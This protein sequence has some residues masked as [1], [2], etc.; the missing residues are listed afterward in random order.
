MPPFRRMDAMRLALITSSFALALAS[1]CDCDGASDNPDAAGGG[2]DGAV[3]RDGSSGADSG[4]GGRDASAT[5]RD[6]S[7]SAEVCDGVDND[8]NGIVDDVDVGGDGICDCL[9]IATLGI[10]G[11]WGNGDVFAAW[12]DARSDIGATALTDQV[13]T[14][15]L[16]EPYQ[17]IVA[18]DIRGREYSASEVDALRQWIEA[19]GGFMTLIG[20]GDPSE[21]TNVNALLMPS[22][23]QYD[24]TPILAGSPTVPITTWHPHPVSMSVTQ[25]GVDNGYEVI[26]AG[27]VIAEEGGFDVLRAV[28]L[29]Q[30]KVL[31][32]GDEW[33][34]YDSE[35]TGH[36]E[37]QLERFWLNAIKWLTPQDECQVPILI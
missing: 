24:A 28:E 8:G 30:G 10:A 9:I 11:E 29:G 25:V 31:V 20:Y 1:G 23:I 5:G 2:G 6:G 16:L 3:V 22:G 26:G 21:R 4:G 19:G 35:W 18:E 14:P 36:P 33:I 15:E 27:T 34:T 7:S 17:V 37:Y 32:W 13:L 12:L